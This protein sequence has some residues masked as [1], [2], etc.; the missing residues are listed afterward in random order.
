MKLTGFIMKLSG[1][2]L[3]VEL[4]NG[5]VVQGTVIG[6]DVA[7]NMHLKSVKLALKGKNPVSMDALSVRGSTIRYVMCVCVTRE[8]GDAGPTFAAGRAFTRPSA[9]PAH[10]AHQPF[11]QLPRPPSRS[12][13]DSLNLDQLLVD[14]TPRIKPAAERSGRGGR[15]RGRGGRGGRGRG[16]GG[17]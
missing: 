11:T 5:T 15:G 2:T 6:S 9:P 4:K 10:C 3:S 17:A 14:D 13:P 7:M 16:R 12:L 8:G 1:E